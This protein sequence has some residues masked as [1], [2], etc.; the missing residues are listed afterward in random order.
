MT[1]FRPGTFPQSV[2]AVI[3]VD[4]CFRYMASKNSFYLGRVYPD[5]GDSL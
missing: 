2:N 1:Q 5:E 4:S 3:E